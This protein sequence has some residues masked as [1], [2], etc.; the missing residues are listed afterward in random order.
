MISST[1]STRKKLIDF[2]T[3]G[4]GTMLRKILKITTWYLE[5]RVAKTFLVH[6]SV[7]IN[8]IRG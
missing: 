8:W 2:W 1:C 7:T 5:L 4:Y 6:M 3:H